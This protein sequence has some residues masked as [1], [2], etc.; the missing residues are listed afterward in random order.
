MEV[1][2]INI[3]I[4]TFIVLNLTITTMVLILVEGS[5]LKLPVW[6]GNILGKGIQL[7]IMAGFILIVGVKKDEL[8]KALRI[9][10]ISLGKA[11]ISL[12]IG[13]MLIPLALFINNLSMLFVTNEFQAN[14]QSIYD[15]PIW[16]QLIVI[17][18]IPAIVEELIFRGLI[19]G[20]YNKV[21]VIWAA[22][23]SGLIF[24]CFHLNINQFC[25]AFVMGIIFALL[26]EVMDSLY[27]SILAHFAFNTFNIIVGFLNRNQGNVQQVSINSEFIVSLLILGG[28][29]IVFT[30]GAVLIIYIFAKKNGKIKDLSLKN[31]SGI[32]DLYSP[33]VMAT[34]L[35]CFFFMITKEI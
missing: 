21:N 4:P 17:A 7:A 23:L 16:I 33:V 19:F 24:G 28:L 32:Q 6:V 3:F 18:V 13:Y 8:S 2:K 14:S 27:A 31:K 25:Y 34:I 11:V 12:L 15:S 9:K 26:V 29:A 22:I 5:G 20:T 30:V 1:K 35:T 10:K